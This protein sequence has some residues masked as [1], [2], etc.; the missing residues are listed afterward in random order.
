VGHLVDDLI[1][2]GRPLD[3]LTAAQLVKA[4]SQSGVQITLTDTQVSNA[5]N[6]LNALSKRR[7]TG[8]AAPEEMAR[9]LAARKG[10]LVEQKEWIVAQ[11]DAIHR[12]RQETAERIEALEERCS[13]PAVHRS[14][15]N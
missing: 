1:E 2:T 10:S 8:G 12:A 7:H 13:L 14:T 5:L 11:R 3:T 4:A 15:D 6:P 9:L